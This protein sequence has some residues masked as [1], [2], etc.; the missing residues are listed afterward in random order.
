MYSHL[1]LN[2]THPPLISI[3]RS[4]LTIL[5]YSKQGFLLYHTFKNKTRFTGTKCHPFQNVVD[6][7]VLASILGLYRFSALLAVCLGYF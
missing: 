6:R 2:I 3:L 4:T 1:E 7:K 5:G